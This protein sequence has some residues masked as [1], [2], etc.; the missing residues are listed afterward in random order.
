MTPAGPARWGRD[1]I[2]MDAAARPSIRRRLA[3][4]AAGRL[5]V[6]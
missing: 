2:R 5:E 3:D 4:W 1:A 6:S